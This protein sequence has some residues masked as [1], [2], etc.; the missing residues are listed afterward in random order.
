MIYQKPEKGIRI[1]T[2]S[3]AVCLVIFIITLYY[4]YRVLFTARITFNEVKMFVH[5]L[6]Q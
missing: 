5:L 4:L 1:T 3:A 2:D 6:Q